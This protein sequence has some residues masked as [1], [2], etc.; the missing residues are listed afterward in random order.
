[1]TTTELDVLDEIAS[2]IKSASS[3][4]ELCDAI[5]EFRDASDDEADDENELKRRGVDLCQLPAFGGPEPRDTTNVWSWDED[6]LMIANGDMEIIARKD[7]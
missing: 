2:R 1:M 5:N 7:V 4:R 6:S 3:L